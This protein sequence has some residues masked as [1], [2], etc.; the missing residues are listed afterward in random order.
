MVM[1]TDA[2]NEPG[3]KRIL[4]EFRAGRKNAQAIFSS[5]LVADAE[6]MQRLDKHLG[7]FLKELRS[8]ATKHE[9]SVLRSHAKEFEREL[10]DE[11]L[12]LFKATKKDL[13]LYDALL[14]DLTAYRKE[15]RELV[16]DDKIQPLVASELKY[17]ELLVQTAHDKIDTLALLFRKLK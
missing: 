14:H 8:D 11:L 5:R 9:S 7:A 17:A 10:H 2:T 4:E 16:Q 3:S 1:A 13:E 15:L 12:L 6:E